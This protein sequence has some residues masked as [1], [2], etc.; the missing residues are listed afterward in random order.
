MVSSGG[1]VASGRDRTYVRAAH[2]DC[3]Q[4]WETL[5]MIYQTRANEAGG[6]G[7]LLFNVQRLPKSLNHQYIRRGRGRQ[8]DLDPEIK[9]LRDEFRL[10]FSGLKWS[11]VGVLA[12]IIVFRSPSWL[13]K[14]STVRDVDIDNKVKPLLD[15]FEQATGIRDSRFWALHAFKA[16]GDS[17]KTDVALYDLGDIIPKK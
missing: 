13:T 2:Q 15:A 12:A 7:T 5:E 10:R 11:P 9:L 6:A 1:S 17:D 3:A 16:L 8:Y 4:V 14:E